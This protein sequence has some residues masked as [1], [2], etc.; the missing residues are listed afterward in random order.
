MH[1]RI[2]VIDMGAEDDFLVLRVTRLSD[3]MRESF[4]AARID[5]LITDPRRA[6]EI[7]DRLRIL[8]DWISPQ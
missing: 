1:A 2:K 5:R 4:A 8:A 3:D 6:R 7:A